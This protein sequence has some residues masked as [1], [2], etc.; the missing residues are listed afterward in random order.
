MKRYLIDPRNE[1]GIYLRGDHLLFYLDIR[2]AVDSNHAKS[3]PSDVT[4]EISN[5]YGTEVLAA[6][7]MTEETTG[8]F[9]YDYSIP[10]DVCYGRYEIT[11]ST[12]TY[13]M[14]KKFDFFIF[15]WEIIT[16]IRRYS[17][18]GESQTISDNDLAAIAFKS[19][20]EV[21]DT[22]Y[23]YHFEEKPRND[24]EYGC[25]DGTN[26]IVRTKTGHL[27]DH[28]GDG[29]VTGWGES[30]C[31][32]DVDGYWIDS[33]YA[34]HQCKITVNDATTGRIT[35]T[36]TDGTAIPSSNCGVFITYWAQWKSFQTKLFRDA[37][38]LLAAFEATRRFNQLDRATLADIESNKVVFL[39]DPNRLEKEYYKALNKIMRPMFG[40]GK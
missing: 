36:Q 24:P 9:S 22:I 20:K 7:S 12:A 14:I 32:T 27:A 33:D 25:L 4:I 1:D 21:L 16:D 23:D 2:D 10:T 15:P 38:S 37:V 11:I 28:D 5:E 6:I 3:S 17:G 13:S 26:S 40:G 18:I 34:K 30:S 35:V 19:Y 8:E 29:S 39:A 31:G